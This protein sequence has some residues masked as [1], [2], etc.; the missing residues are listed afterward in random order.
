[1]EL[2]FH[3]SLKLNKE[4]NILVIFLGDGATEEGVF[5]ESLDFASL[6]DLPVLFVCENNHYSVYSHI[7]KRQSRKRNILKIAKAIGIDG[8]SING[9]DAISIYSKTK[10][11]LKKVRQNSK[12]YFV[13]LDTFRFLEHCGPDN[14]DILNYR[15]TKYLNEWKKNV[16]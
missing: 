2:E 6:H 1:M 3:G 13:I 12:P 14:D 15:E 16:L 11:L 10:K 9:N 7:S 4:K 5:Q 8:C